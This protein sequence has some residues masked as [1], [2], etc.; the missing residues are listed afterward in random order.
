MDIDSHPVQNFQTRH[1]DV[2]AFPLTQT[3]IT[4]VRHTRAVCSFHFRTLANGMMMQR[5]THEDHQVI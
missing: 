4:S 5:W 3:G 2:F 1:V